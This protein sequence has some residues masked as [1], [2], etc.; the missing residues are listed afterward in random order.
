MQ[1]KNVCSIVRSMEKDFVNGVVRKSKYVELSPYEDIQTIDAYLNSKHL[2]GKTDSQGREKPF[3]NIV[4]SARNIWYR[5]TDIDRKNIKI[6]SSKIKHSIIALLANAHLQDYMRTENFGRFLNKMGLVMASHNEVVVKAVEKNGDLHLSVVPWDTLIFDSINFYQNPVIEKLSFTVSEL[7][8]KGYD[9]VK[10][11]ELIDAYETR[12]TIDGQQKDDKSNYINIYEVHG[13]FPLSFIT[14]KDTDNEIYT[15]QVHI[16]SYIMNDKGEYED[17]TLY[18]G[19]EDFPYMVGSLIEEPDGQIAFNGAVKNLFEAQWIVNDTEKKKYDQLEL[20]SMLIF[21]T[22]D[23]NFFNR[24]ALTKILNGDIL[25]HEPN[26]PITQVNNNSHDITSLSNFGETWKALG[27]QINGI[28]EA[29][30]GAMPKSGTAWRQTE[31]VLNES[32]NLYE[33]MT[34]NKG[35]FIEEIIKEKIIPHIKKKNFKT[36][37]EIA[38][39]LES[40]EL[41]LIDSRFIKNTS[42]SFVNRLLVNK[43]LNDEEPTPEEQAELILKSEGQVKDLMR[44][45]GNRRMFK[46]SEVNW[47]KEFEDFDWNSLEIDIT[48]E[49]RDVQEVLT[50]L[51]SVLMFFARKQGQPLTQQEELI[52]NKIL[53]QTGHLFPAEIAQLE[54]KTNVPNIANTTSIQQG[55]GSGII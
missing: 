36:N 6:K 22:A 7:I 44:P 32:Y 47:Q 28:S 37:K 23:K 4:V 45:L 43:V 31:A 26:S 14:E 2:S 12:K 38:Y 33:L 49:Q 35:L 50:T 40:N 10:T 9:M 54:E 25:I 11:K 17:F 27:N 13:K 24:N 41:S 20:A 18:K 52:I 8:E 21:Q 15:N 16:I 48:G 5:A 19:K 29:M 51:N 30:L 46:P 3:A 42:V 34:E 55:Q 1:D 53:A 39:D